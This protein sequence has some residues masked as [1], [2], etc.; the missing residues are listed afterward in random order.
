ME[1]VHP[2]QAEACERKDASP[3]EDEETSFREQRM[4]R[5]KGDTHEQQNIS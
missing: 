1:K 2:A 3:T 5:K 4:V